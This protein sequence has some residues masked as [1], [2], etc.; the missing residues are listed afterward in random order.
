[1][2][3]SQTDD[4]LSIPS[5]SSSAVDVDDTSNA[6]SIVSVSGRPFPDHVTQALESFYNRGMIGWGRSHS[7][8]FTEALHVTGLT[9]IQLKVRV[10]IE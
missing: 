9:D 3:T 10:C 4:D 2:A 7:I 6:S 8:E 1:M 5:S